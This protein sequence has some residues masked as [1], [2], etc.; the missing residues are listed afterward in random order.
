[1]HA[2]SNNYEQASLSCLDCVRLAHGMSRQGLLVQYLVGAAI[3]GIGI[4]ELRKVAQQLD[5]PTA[6]TAAVE[7]LQI[8]MMRFGAC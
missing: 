8:E 3:G 4:H 5:S 2:T 7:L 1:M 6:S